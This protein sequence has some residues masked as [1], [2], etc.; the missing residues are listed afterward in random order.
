MIRTFFFLSITFFFTLSSG[1]ETVETDLSH[2]DS[3][4]RK[5][6]APYELPEDH[7]IWPI[8]SSLF[9]QERVTQNELSLIAAGFTI[10][11]LQPRSFITVASHPSLPGYLFKIYLD[12][13]RRK[14]LGIDWWKWFHRRLQ[15]VKKV[16]K[17]LTFIN[18]RFFKAPKKWIY[19]L[20]KEPYPLENPELL[21]KDEILIV[22]NMDLASEAENLNAW[23]TCI[24]KEHLDELFFI[25]KY[26]GGSSYRP[27]NIAL[28]NEGTFA[29]IDTEYPQKKADFN[30]ITPFLSDEMQEYWKR[31]IKRG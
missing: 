21:R 1:L 27:D 13:Q 24:T 31:K 28:T 12:A 29:F 9:S 14:K 22:E 19:F 25:M 17:A 8:V 6:L 16:Q 7:P 15:G 20:P 2:V 26:G 18:S 10:L 30:T 3:K 11:H 4:E 5:A 23:K